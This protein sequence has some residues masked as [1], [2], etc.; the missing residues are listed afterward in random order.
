MPWSK[1]LWVIF[2]DIA[3][4]KSHM[5]VCVVS[6]SPHATVFFVHHLHTMG[7]VELFEL[8]ALSQE[9]SCFTHLKMYCSM[10]LLTKKGGKEHAAVKIISLLRMFGRHGLPGLDNRSSS[11]HTPFLSQTRDII[12]GSLQP[13][14]TKT[15]PSTSA[16][17]SQSRRAVVLL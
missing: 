3:S 12:S 7:K 11:S 9:K 8:V 1:I 16:S 15:N 10:W 5:Y 14:L 6:E 4:K 17:S 13:P 2:T